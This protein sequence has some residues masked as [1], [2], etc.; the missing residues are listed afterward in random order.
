MLAVVAATLGVATVVGMVLLWPQDDPR[1]GSERLPLV[2][3][4]YD[5]EVVGA[6]RQ[7][8]QG[9]TPSQ[10][11]DCIRVRFRPSQGPDVGEVLELDLPVSLTTP[12]VD[13]GDHVVFSYDAKAD[14][15]FRYQF[16]DRQRRPLLLWLTALFVIVVI[17][18]ARW[19]GVAARAE[20]TERPTTPRR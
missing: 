5:V 17:A 8:C 19:R 9:T 16:N 15:G 2:S 7:P 3:T 18:L 4:V 1:R 13:P 20:S 11:I 12:A 14:P 6:A 10:A